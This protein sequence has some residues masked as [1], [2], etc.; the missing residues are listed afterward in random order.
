[1]KTIQV[2]VLLALSVGSVTFGQLPPC[3]EAFRSWGLGVGS[4]IPPQGSC[5]SLAAGRSFSLS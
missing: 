3:V 2:A 5:V 4:A 1:M